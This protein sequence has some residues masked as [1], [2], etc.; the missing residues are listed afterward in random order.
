MT[1]TAEVA[2]DAEDKTGFPLCVLCVL[3]GMKETR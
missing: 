1:F 2:E 3:S